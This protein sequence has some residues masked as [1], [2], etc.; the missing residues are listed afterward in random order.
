MNQPTSNLVSFY[1]WLDS[2]GRTRGT[3]WRWR[4]KGIIKAVNVFGKLYIS[5]DEIAR[6]EARAVAGEFAD[7]SNVLKRRTTPIK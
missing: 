6:F 5:R 7:K 3:G 4:K 2:L 1:G